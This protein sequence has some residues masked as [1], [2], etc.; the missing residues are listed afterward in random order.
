MFLPTDRFQGAAAAG[1]IAI[2]VSQGDVAPVLSGAFTIGFTLALDQV[3][4]TRRRSSELRAREGGRG[5][6]EVRKGK[7]K[8]RQTDRQ[9]YRQSR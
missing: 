9:T 4:G 3:R 2:G 7:Q 1:L 6:E 5:A 8:E